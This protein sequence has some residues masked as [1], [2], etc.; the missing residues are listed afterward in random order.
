MK[1]ALGLIVFVV[2]T[3]FTAAV[4]PLVL[5]ENSVS[6]ATSWQE[7]LQTPI[8]TESGEMVAGELDI[9]IL[10]DGTITAEFKIVDPP[11]FATRIPTTTLP[12]D[13][14]GGPCRVIVDA[15]NN[16]ILFPLGQDINS[17]QIPLVASRE[18]ADAIVRKLQ[19]AEWSYDADNYISN[20]DAALSDTSGTNLFRSPSLPQK[21]GQAFDEAYFGRFWNVITPNDIDIYSGILRISYTYPSD[22]LPWTPFPCYFPCCYLSAVV[23][24]NVCDEDQPGFRLDWLGDFIRQFAPPD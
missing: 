12:P 7:A 22:P 5:M 20:L 6:A 13:C 9:Q 2:L 11:P 8:P 19:S 24:S 16:Q 14:F 18:Q 4:I 21:Y 3:V 10:P 23:G 17:L 1:R 15:D